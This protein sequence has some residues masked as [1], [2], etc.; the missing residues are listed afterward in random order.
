[1]NLKISGNFY[2]NQ[3]IEF[4]PCSQEIEILIFVGLIVN[5]IRSYISVLMFALLLFP[6]VEKTLHDFEHV[7]DIHCGIKEV[8]YCKAEHF[9]AICD[10][11]F[12]SS[13][14]PPKTQEQVSV[15][16]THVDSFKS[17]LVFNTKLSPK[18]KLSLR[19]PPII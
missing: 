1:M 6:M 8:H 3:K 5:K 11:V 13:A 10:Y 14:T 18:F 16:S 17:L 19:G 12:S 7:N 15:F 2:K 4:L 9:C